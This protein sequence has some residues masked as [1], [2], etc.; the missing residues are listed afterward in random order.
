MS[1]KE[2]RETIFKQPGFTE[3]YIEA[4]SEADFALTIGSDV[5][6]ARKARGMT[7]AQLAS[8]LGTYQSSIARI[9]K[10]QKLPAMRFLFRIAGA[11]R[12]RLI[13]P[14]FDIVQAEV[15]TTTSAS[16]QVGLVQ[17]AFLEAHFSGDTRTDTSFAIPSAKLAETVTV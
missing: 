11:L 6:A 9:E 4:Y 5:L 17:D 12:T 15:K 10:G 1:Y 7:Q 2:Y 16:G 8:K 13:P 14:R 3:A